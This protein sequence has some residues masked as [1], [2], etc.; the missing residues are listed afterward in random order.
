MYARI[1]DINTIRELLGSDD[2]TQAMVRGGSTLLVNYT[3]GALYYLYELDGAGEQQDA[4]VET[5]LEIVG[6]RWEN[7]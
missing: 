6:D 1:T 4:A 2:D 3:P 5:M 7:A